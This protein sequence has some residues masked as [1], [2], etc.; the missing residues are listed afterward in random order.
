MAESFPGGVLE[1]AGTAFLRPRPREDGEERVAPGD[2]SAACRNIGE[3]RESPR[4]EAARSRELDGEHEP[5]RGE[6]DRLPE[7]VRGGL[8]A[9]ICPGWETMQ[10]GLRVDRDRG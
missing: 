2:G 5:P 7:D 4:I 3:G 10:E 8:R 1:G 6:D 9:S